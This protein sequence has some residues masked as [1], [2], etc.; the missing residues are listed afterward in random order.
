MCGAITPT[1]VHALTPALP[2]SFDSHIRIGDLGLAHRMPENTPVEAEATASEASDDEGDGVV[3]S[4]EYLDAEFEEAN[5]VPS[6]DATWHKP[7]GHRV[8]GHHAL[9]PCPRVAHCLRVCVDR[10]TAA[11]K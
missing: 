2:P 8:C 7:T 6:L 9:P 5:D 1:F 3:M 11:P 4:L 10:P